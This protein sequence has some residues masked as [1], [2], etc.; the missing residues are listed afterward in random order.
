MEYIIKNREPERLFQIFEEISAI[1]RG[2]GN[3]KGIADYICAFAERLGL[4]YIR[5]EVDNVFIRKDAGVGYEDRPSVLLQG[6][7][8]MVC[9]KNAGTVHDFT[10]DPLKLRIKD[11]FLC[12]EGTTLGADDGVA[13]AMMLAIL[14]S[15]EQLPEIEC[16]FTVG[17]ETG[18]VGAESFD[19]SVIRSKKMIN[20]DSEGEGI[21]VVSS[22]GGADVCYSVNTDKVSCPERP[23]R[24][25]VTGLMGGHSGTDID[26]CRM[27]ANRV[28]GR[29][30]SRLYEKKPF[31]LTLIN[32]GNMKNAIARECV[33]DL[34]VLDAKLVEDEIKVIEKE[35]VSE[36]CKEDKGLHIYIKKGAVTDKMFTY[37]DTS[38]IIALLTLTPNGVYAMSSDFKGLVRTSCNCGLVETDDSGVKIWVKTRSSLESEHQA[39]ISTLVRTGDLV[40]ADSEVSG[41]YESWDYCADSKL[42]EQFVSTF[43]KLFPDLDIEPKTAAIHAGLECGII[44]SRLGGCDTIAI[45]PDVFDIHSPDERLDLDSFERFWK[46]VLT[47]IKE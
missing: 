23:I 16:L 47:L 41:E 22:A 8:D 30:L 31:N 1:P 24:I 34:C 18:L 12:A 13:V 6:H 17:E 11:G 2:S 43:K 39:L 9:E 4:F 27:N 29:I 25:I 5:D 10:K 40:G 28:M 20:M 26:A 44:I 14:E 46:L 19:Y 33:A 36:A 42:A 7:T 35:L 21:A 37:K 45:G 32:G 3:E 38:E 15:N